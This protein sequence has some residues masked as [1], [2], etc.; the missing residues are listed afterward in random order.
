MSLALLGAVPQTQVGIPLWTSR[1]EAK[2]GIRAARSLKQLYETA[3]K[4][5]PSA[6]KYKALV[7]PIVADADKWD[8][9]VIFYQNSEALAIGRRAQAVAQQLAAEY[10]LPPISDDPALAQG[11]FEHLQESGKKT[12]EAGTDTLGEVKKLLPWVVGGVVIIGAGV[13]VGP[14][15]APFLARR[16]ALA[17][18]SGK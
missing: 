16:A 5:D 14:L 8:A 11:F 12:L 2:A 15:V 13:I 10:G 4:K 9:A 6:V 18:V 3:V 1:E 7:D 17:A